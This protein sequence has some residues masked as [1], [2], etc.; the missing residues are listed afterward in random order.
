MSSTGSPKRLRSV[1]AR[2]ARSKGPPKDVSSTSTGPPSSLIGFCTPTVC[3]NFSMNFSGGAT[4]LLIGVT[5]PMTEPMTTPRSAGPQPYDSVA[6][7]ITPAAAP[8]V[9]QGTLPSLQ[10]VKMIVIEPVCGPV[11]SPE[12]VAAVHVTAIPPTVSRTLGLLLDVNVLLNG[13][14]NSG[15][16][17]EAGTSSDRACAAESRAGA[18]GK[19]EPHGLSRGGRLDTPGF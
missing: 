6:L 12:F 13:P 10:P 16:A 11:I 15:R 2:P 4:S 17:A 3:A 7:A 8:G 19:R 5:L 9:L 14:L 1:D 18:L